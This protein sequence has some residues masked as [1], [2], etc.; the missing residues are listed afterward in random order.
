MPLTRIATD[1]VNGL[2]AA[3]STYV[4]ERL[5]ELGLE[6][7][8]RFDIALDHGQAWL[9]ATLEELLA[10][11]Y[12]EQRRGPL[13]VFQE[14]MRF[15]TEALAAAGA[16]AVARAPG[17][18]AALPGD[19]YN[20]APASS[21]RL[22]DEVWTAHVAWG[23]AKARR[24]EQARL[25][26]LLSANLMDRATIEPLVVRSGSEFA[27]WDGRA[28]VVRFAGGRLPD[29]VLADLALPDAIA[30]IEDLAQAG[31]RVIA[32]GP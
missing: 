8:K 18:V 14:A 21:R 6:R 10:L 31:V 2:T 16:E 25:V 22:G 29:L 13:E 23:A 7:P 4:E 5:E 24:L 15:P 28:H 3:F 27:V 32:F 17:A 12:G 9:R 30:A 1:V 20:L 26:G 19:I 11:P